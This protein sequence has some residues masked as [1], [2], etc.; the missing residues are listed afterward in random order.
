M[1]SFK[2]TT[3]S[4]PPATIFQRNNLYNTATHKPS[5]S[6]FSFHP[7]NPEVNPKQHFPIP[8]TRFRH[9][10]GAK[11]PSSI[12][13]PLDAVL[14]DDGPPRSI[15]A[16]HKG[17]PNDIGSWHHLKEKQ[18][19]NKHRRKQHIEGWGGHPELIDD[20]WNHPHNILYMLQRDK[21]GLGVGVGLRCLVPSPP[22]LA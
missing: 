16:W 13:H 3:A 8:S 22:S 5:R 11:K 9:S 4:P 2:T 12:Q 1:R 18:K 14:H 7:K 17:E 10:Q 19:G 20:F 6:L 21:T 15:E